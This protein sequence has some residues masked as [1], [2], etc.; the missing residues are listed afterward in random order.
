MRVVVKC[1]I[2]LQAGEYLIL[3]A[4]PLVALRDA[5]VLAHEHLLGLLGTL[6][7]PVEP[8]QRHYRKLTTMR[9]A[10]GAAMSDREIGGDGRHVVD[11]VEVVH[12]VSV[13]DIGLTT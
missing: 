5:A 6:Q 13:C 12:T 7:L 1:F 9:L 8:C 11:A 3:L 2:L 10:I 4:G